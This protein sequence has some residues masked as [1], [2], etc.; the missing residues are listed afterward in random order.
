MKGTWG[1][2]DSEGFGDGL[3]NVICS[4]TYAGATFCR[5]L[6]DSVMGPNPTNLAL[7]SYLLLQFNNFEKILPN[8]KLIQSD[9]R[10]DCPSVCAYKSFPWDFGACHCAICSKFPRRLTSNR[11]KYKRRWILNEWLILYAYIGAVFQAYDYG[12]KGNSKRYG[13]KK[14]MEYHLDK[15]TAPVMI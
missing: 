6:I 3:L 10:I 7:V 13:T 1:W 12:R 14:P 5:N 15:I 11:I 2:L 9:N 4:Q 8:R